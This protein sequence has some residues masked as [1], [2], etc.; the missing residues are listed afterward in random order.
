MKD[1]P[2]IFSGPMV[3]ALLDGTKT[4]TRRLTK[5]QDIFYRNGRP[6]VPTGVHSEAEMTKPGFAVG[7]RLWVRESCK[8]SWLDLDWQYSADG[9]SVCT[10][11]HFHPDRP[12]PDRWPRGS[13]PAIH[14][15]RNISRLTLTV[16]DVRVE[17]LQKISEA[18]AQAEGIATWHQEVGLSSDRW[19][20]KWCRYSRMVQQQRGIVKDCACDLGA[21]A[22]L[23]DSINGDREGAA[24]ADNPWVAAVTF[25]VER[26][27]IDAPSA[28]AKEHA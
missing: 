4:Q 1:R 15:A 24:W 10:E 18:D 14:M 12:T 9:H 5:R 19:T 3:R 22:L 6:F 2:I 27:N 13:M 16:T 20:N 17:R 26:R 7:D 11:R 21:F 23:W 25:T 28:I 8:Y